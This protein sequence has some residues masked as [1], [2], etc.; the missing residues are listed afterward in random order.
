M[1]PPTK[2]MLE[3]VLATVTKTRARWGDAIK[4]DDLREKGG[5]KR[6]IRAPEY[7][8]FLDAEIYALK[9]ALR[10]R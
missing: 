1:T 5:D 4:E 9:L 2:E 7:V 8:E 10:R 6:K 3:T